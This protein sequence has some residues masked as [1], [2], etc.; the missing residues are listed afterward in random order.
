MTQISLLSGVTTDANAEFRT[1]LPVNLIPVPKDTGISK[2][3]LRVAP[4]LTQFCI[5]SGID[6]GGIV[7]LGN[8][9]LY[10]VMGTK[11]VRIGA[12][13][14]VFQIGDVGGAAPVSMDYSFDW[15]CVISN[16]NAF[17]CSDATVLQITDPDLG[18]PIDVVWMD[19]Y[20]VFTDG[21]FIYVN[22]LA[23][24]FS[25]DP[26]KYG[27]SEIDPDKVVGL[28]K[29][30]NELY[31]LNRTTIEVFDNIGSTGFPFT[32]VPGGLIQK[33]CVGTRAK[34]LFA[35]SFAWVGSGRGEPCSIYLAAGGA[36]LKLATREVETRLAAYSEAQLATCIVEAKADRMHQHLIVHLPNETLVY[37]ATASIIAG[38]PVWF[39]LSTSSTGIAPYRGCF[40]TFAYGKW[41]VGDTADARL[42]YVDES[43][44][45]QYGA[46][47]GWQFDTMFLYNEGRGAIV[48]SMELVGTTGRAIGADDPLVYHSYTLDGENWT[49]ERTARMGMNGQTAQRV[50]FFDAGTMQNFRGDRFRGL[51]SARATWARLEADLEPLNA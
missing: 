25:I 10:R 8:G 35:D 1:S 32:R 3:A 34:C 42:G 12:D 37:D 23:D 13:A 27:S 31:V 5:G 46:A 7:N 28:L 6:R 11:F 47:V 43:V 50:V 39:F 45:T 17:L 9:T 20:F 4:G 51:S 29:H 2:G 26:L 24:P 33:G 36:A 15:I 18:T 38:E 44:V 21:S 41:L 48:H 16:G 14:S 40:F 30:R 19:G 22:D 49:A